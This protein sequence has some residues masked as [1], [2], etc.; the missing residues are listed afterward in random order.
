MSD[1][2]DLDLIIGKLDRISMDFYK[3]LENFSLELIKVKRIL[4]YSGKEI[5]IPKKFFFN[6]LKPELEKRKK[7]T[8]NEIFGICEERRKYNSYNTLSSYL[9]KL[10]KNEYIISEKIKNEKHYMLSYKTKKVKN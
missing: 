2:K 10:E 7:I 1:K 4:N 8:K 3:I 6:F 5:F 9:H